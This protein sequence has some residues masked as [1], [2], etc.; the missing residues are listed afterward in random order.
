M[1][2]HRTKK[3]RRWARLRG[4]KNSY[5]VIAVLN[6]ATHLT[7]TY[8][9]P[10]ISMLML[11]LHWYDR[12]KI[13]CKLRSHR[14][15]ESRETSHYYV[16]PAVH[17]VA[18]ALTALIRSQK[19]RMHLVPPSLVQCSLLLTFENANWGR[20]KRSAGWRPNHAIG[21]IWKYL[22]ERSEKSNKK[23]KAIWSH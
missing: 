10:W 19:N 4:T 20:N 1:T 18:S 13:G 6:L 8:Y 11:W 2:V 12:N 5:G 3:R 23:W 22:C 14:C 9:Q 7:T 15:Y 17:F 16:L 21:E